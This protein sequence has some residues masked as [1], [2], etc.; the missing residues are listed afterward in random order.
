[1]QLKTEELRYSRLGHAQSRGLEL[2][3]IGVTVGLL[4]MTRRSPTIPLLSMAGVRARHNALV[5]R[6]NS[7]HDGQLVIFGEYGRRRRGVREEEG[8]ID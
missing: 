8:V 3:H 1:M 6:K 7:T 2:L 5:A 4:A